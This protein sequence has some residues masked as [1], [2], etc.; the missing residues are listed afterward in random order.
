[1]A[2][3][4][5]SSSLFRGVDLGSHHSVCASAT[6]TEPH[7]I[8]VDVNALGNRSTPSIISLD[9]RQ[10]LIGEAAEGSVGKNPKQTFTHLVNACFEEGTSGEARD[11]RS[12]YGCFW[13]VENGVDFDGEERWSEWEPTSEELL[14]AYLKKL[15]DLK[16]VE[17]NAKHE[18]IVLALP[19]YA[20][21]GEV[22]TMAKKL[23][24]A[25]AVAGL[26]KKSEAAAAAAGVDLCYHSEALATQWV[27]KFESRLVEKQVGEVEH[28]L[29]VDVGYAHT[30][31]TLVKVGLLAQEEKKDEAMPMEV[32]ESSASPKKSASTSEET[33]AAPKLSVSVVKKST[34][35]V[36]VHDFIKQLAQFGVDHA[37][38]KYSQSIKLNSK[39]GFKLKTA[40]QKALK[41]LSMLPEASVHLECFLEDEEDFKLDLRR[42]DLEEALAT[43]LEQVRSCVAET[44]QVME[45]VKIAEESSSASSSSFVVEIVGGGV[46]IPCVA[47]KIEEAAK[48]APCSAGDATLLGRGLDGSSAV[49][50]GACLRAGGKC[51]QLESEAAT[52]LSGDASSE[53]GLKRVLATE[54]KMEQIEQ[55]EEERLQALN[56]L[57]SYIFEA[58]RILGEASAAALFDDVAGLTSHLDTTE[59]WFL[60]NVQDES[61][62]KETYQEKY[63]ETK[64]L[65]EVTHGAKYFADLEAKKAATEA[66]LEKLNA[67]RQAEE[68][69]DHDNRNLPKSERL[70]MA[71][72]QRVE[73]NELFKAGTY[74]DAIMRYQKAHAHLAKLFDCSPDELKEKDRISLS[75][76]LNTAQCYL[77]GIDA[78]AP[79]EKE[80]VRQ[81]AQKVVRQCDSALDIEAVHIKA[82]FR[83]ATALEKMGEIDDARASTKK[84]MSSEEGAKNPDIVRLDKKL[85]RA[86]AVQKQ[87]AQ[88]MFGK[89]FGS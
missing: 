31:A 85:E 74:Q 44:L 30:T 78:T 2:T 62:G 15:V 40:M 58:R 23:E 46:R 66:E 75:C 69:E 29:I 4:T 32:D 35:M 55:K 5:S 42:S 86:Q 28:L 70:R 9:G 68:K 18:K 33:P 25:L 19:D 10:R 34:V 26:G 65:V 7:V 27:A 79:E 36:G 57:E 82:L 48:A 17:K 22:A 20:S 59:N 81:I 3:P 47:A 63:E 51:F 37:Q 89:M 84:A 56:Q 21:E 16:L 61:I 54:S 67:A 76:Y 38:K 60:D 6:A 8:R 41:E 11:V 14:G 64:Q 39:K 53:G 88:K 87:K 83:K 71:E 13:E 73:G 52:L 49:A 1:M 45:T 24:T 80:K 77:K 50:T 43:Q 72:K 12:H